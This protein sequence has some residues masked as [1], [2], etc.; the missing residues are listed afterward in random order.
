[1]IIA[2]MLFVQPDFGDSQVQPPKNRR[3][4]WADLGY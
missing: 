2:V 1:M 4:W 3:M